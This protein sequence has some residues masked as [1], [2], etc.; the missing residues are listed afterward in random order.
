MIYSQYT[1][2]QKLSITHRIR[3]SSTSPPY[4]S[5]YIQTIISYLL[6]MLS[7]TLSPSKP[8]T[9]T[10]I[11][12]PFLSSPLHFRSHSHLKPITKHHHHKKQLISATLIQPSSSSSSSKPPQKVYQPFRP[13]LSQAPIPPQFR[14]L[15]TEARLDVLTNRLGQWY[16]YA[17]LI[18]PLI[19]EGFTP[20]TIEEITGIS[21]IEQNRLVVAAQVRESLVQAGL[22]P[23]ILEFFDKGGAE[24]LYEI[25]TVSVSQRPAVA[26]YL[27]ENRFEPGDAEELARAIKDYPRRRGDRGWEWFDYNIPADCLAFMYYRQALEYRETEPR[28]TALQKALDV[29]VSEQARAWVLKE[30][31][32]TDEDGEGQGRGGGLVDGVKVPVVRLNLGEIAEATV[33]SVLPVCRSND[34]GKEVEEAPWEC[35]SKGDFGIVE[36]EKGWTK[37][38]VLPAWDPVMNLKRG[39]VVVA[40]SDA[41]ALPWR[42]NRWYKE[43]SILVVADRGRK[44]VEVDNGFYLILSEDEL[45]VERGSILKE[46]GVTESLGTVV[47]VVRPPKEDDGN[48]ME[49]ED[50]E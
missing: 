31:D 30:L 10:S 46:K 22:D 15:D 23:Q 16:E 7:F 6:K 28:L 18:P 4:S 2:T 34:R 37:W 40:F 33:V 49:I 35:E 44:E 12:S 43:E 20:P 26:T 17:P 48:E 14:N 19:S 39:G 5:Q 27:S 25:R 8:T 50:W 24:L 47:I 21:G 11:H 42:V 45:K 3:F 32:G 36:A 38:V 9:T 1:N 13:P 41:R 29:A